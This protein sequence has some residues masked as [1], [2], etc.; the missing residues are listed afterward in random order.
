MVAETTTIAVNPKD[1]SNL[2]AMTL[3][4]VE[5]AEDYADFLTSYVGLLDDADMNGGVVAMDI[6]SVRRM[7]MMINQTSKI[8]TAELMMLRMPVVFRGSADDFR[9]L[10]HESPQEYSAL[11]NNPNRERVARLKNYLAAVDRYN[12]SAREAWNS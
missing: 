10:K 6:D 3:D 9:R 4:M 5:V 12:A 1:T 11:T 2:L 8:A 7:E